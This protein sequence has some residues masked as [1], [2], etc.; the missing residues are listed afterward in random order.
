MGY[1]LLINGVYWGYNPFTNPL[2]TS[3]D[4]Q[5]PPQTKKIPRDLPVLPPFGE[6]VLLGGGF[7]YVLFSSLLGEDSYLN[8]HI[9]QLG[10]STTN[11]FF[12]QTSWPCK[13]KIIWAKFHRHQ[14]PVGPLLEQ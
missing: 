13:S 3:W 2:L 6:Y 9:F 7:K 14:T 5:V 12:F 11:Y 10:V 1:S 8:E 4:I